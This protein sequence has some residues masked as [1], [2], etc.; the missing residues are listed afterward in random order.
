MI[1]LHFKDTETEEQ[2]LAT[3]SWVYKILFKIFHNQLSRRKKALICSM[4]HFTW[5]KSC[6]RGQLQATNVASLSAELR[7]DEHK[8][9]PQAVPL[10]SGYSQ[11]VVERV[12]LS[13]ATWLTSSKHSHVF[14]LRKLNITL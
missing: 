3:C 5:W 13:R 12:I 2:S 14:L 4:H 10:A 1:F 11:N 6:H 8:Q 7:R 9:L